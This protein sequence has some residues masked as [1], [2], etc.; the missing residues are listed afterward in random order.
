MSLP[1]PSPVIELIQAFR[2][3]KAMFTAV[4]L[5]VFD[6]LRESPARAPE[7]AA[8]MAVDAGA[9]ERLLDACAALG[10]LRKSGGVYSND[11]VAGVYLCAASPHSLRGYICYSDAA[12]YP[13]WGNLD[14]AVAEGTHRWKQTFG[15]DGPI[16]DHFFR[17]EEAMR[18]FLLGMH[19]FGMLTS[20][21]VV[22]AFDLGRFRRLVDLGGATGHLAIAACERYPQLRATVF[23]LPRVAPLAREQVALSSARERIEVVAG[24]FFRDDLPPA[25]LYAAGRILHD[26]SEAK[27]DALAGRIYRSLPEGGAFLVAETLLNED[28]VGPLWANLQSL[29]MLLIAEGRERSAA[30]YETLLKRAGFRQVEARRTGSTLD[31]V[32]AVK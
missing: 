11:P 10:L 2:R 15:W 32:L 4:A 30:A 7:L 16:F 23:D 29:S 3:S 6:R 17:T 20:P 19:G 25:D 24:D 5:G 9:L 13:L 27:I 26:W 12:H 28:G 22:T 14:T 31:A 1:D 8:A 18:D 21:R